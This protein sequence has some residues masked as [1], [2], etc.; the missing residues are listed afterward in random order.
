MG[1]DSFRV[2]TS[3]SHKKQIETPESIRKFV[4]SKR[5]EGHEI[6]VMDDSFAS[7]GSY[8]PGLLLFNNQ[9]QLISL[10]SGG[11][12]CRNRSYFLASMSSLLENGDGA[13]ATDSVLLN[14]A[15]QDERTGEMNRY[16]AMVRVHLDMISP[17]LRTLHGDAV[18]PKSLYTD[19]LLIKQFSVSGKSSV[20]AQLI[21]EAIEDIGLLEEIFGDRITIVLLNLDRLFW[22]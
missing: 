10:E 15:I 9:G 16:S 19:Y 5:L 12:V 6:L 13:F 14:F 21:R 7:S 8:L 4:T 22:M 1:C 2:L 20:T 17:F 11:Q 18:D 3:A